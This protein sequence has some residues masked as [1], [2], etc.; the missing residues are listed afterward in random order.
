M[1][2][3][4]LYDYFLAKS[5]PVP[6]KHLFKKPIML[7]FDDGYKGVHTNL[8]P[9][10][11]FL[12]TKYSATVKLV[13]FIN[14]HSLGVPSINNSLAH[15]TCNDLKDGFKKSFYD[16]QSHGFSHSVLTR[17]NI[18]DL[19][20]ELDEAQVA[21]RKCIQLDSNQTVAS[22]IAYPYGILDARV[23]AYTSKY[24]LSG[25]SYENRVLQI[26]NMINNYQIPRL[27]IT[28]ETSLP[29]LIKLAENSSPMRKMLTLQSNSQP[30]F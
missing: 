22:H 24:Y 17:L 27:N 7:T 3:Q 9:F 29:K 23:K 8:F 14:P 25:Y 10:L 18:K 26:D 15:L 28:S 6:S 2:S 13:L 20:F 21:L 19:S 12:K 4:E 16:V 5:K 1:S 30:R 11:E